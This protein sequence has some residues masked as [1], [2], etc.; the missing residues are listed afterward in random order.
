[1]LLHY[2]YQTSHQTKAA[3]N[4]GTHCV[5]CDIPEGSPDHLF[6]EK[7]SFTPNTLGDEEGRKLFTGIE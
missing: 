4:C 2:R 7:H 5:I 3:L 6:H 1:M